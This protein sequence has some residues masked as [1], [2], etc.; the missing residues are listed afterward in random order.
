MAICLEHAGYRKTI[1]LN[2]MM[3]SRPKTQ[4]LLFSQEQFLLTDHKRMRLARLEM[5]SREGLK[6]YSNSRVNHT[7]FVMINSLPFT[8]NL[9]RSLI[10][11]KMIK[12]TFGFV[13]SRTSPNMFLRKLQIG[14][15][16]SLRLLKLERKL[17][18]KPQWKTMI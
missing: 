6:L 4:R 11:K 16:R 10:S 15:P 17:L 8:D 3:H 9:L 12:E 18:K 13:S 7:R 5:R 2:S 14:P 1:R